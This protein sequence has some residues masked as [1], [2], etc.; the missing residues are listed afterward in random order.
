[1]MP[2]ALTATSYFWVSV[3]EKRLVECIF[4]CTD[5]HTITHAHKTSTSWSEENNSSDKG[6]RFRSTANNYAFQMEI[7][8]FSCLT[9]FIFRKFVFS[10]QSNTAPTDRK[11]V[12]ESAHLLGTHKHGPFVLCHIFS[13]ITFVV[14]SFPLFLQLDNEI[15]AVDGK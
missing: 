8:V 4:D 11:C 2:I 15:W 7:R 1:M 10:L 14:E 12:C 13:L 3:H 6:T 9:A 5:A